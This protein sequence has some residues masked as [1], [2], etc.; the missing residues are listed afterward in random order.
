MLK[1]LIQ[2]DNDDF[3]I[4]I[5]SLISQNA[6]LL[7]ELF[8]KQQPIELRESNEV[9]GAVLPASIYNKLAGKI[10][11]TSQETNIKQFENFKILLVDDSRLILSSLE[12][13]LK[14]L[15]YSNFSKAMTLD[16]AYKEYHNYKPDLIILDIVMKETPKIKNGIELLQLIKQSDLETKIIM[17]S[18][19]SDKPTIVKCLTS[20]ANGYL[21]KPFT[22]DKLKTTIE[23][24]L[25]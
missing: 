7:K 24:L 13:E 5:E 12:K 10:D 6:S 14:K 23:S 11:N 22:V 17:L 25:V 2:Q 21:L 1:N 16:G 3:Y 8:E 18:G 20:G 15:G 9:I 19:N 4:N